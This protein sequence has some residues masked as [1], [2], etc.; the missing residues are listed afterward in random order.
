MAH[1]SLRQTVLTLRNQDNVARRVK[2]YPPDSPF[3]EPGAL[4]A[5]L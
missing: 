3:F 2:V 1:I 4:E 5:W